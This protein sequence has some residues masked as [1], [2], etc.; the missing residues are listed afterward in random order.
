VTT[1]PPAAN[2]PAVDPGATWP[3]VSNRRP[4][5]TGTVNR[6]DPPAGISPATME[7]GRQRA[8]DP[9]YPEWLSHVSGAAGCTRPIRLSGQIH[10]GPF[11]I[12]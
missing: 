4:T 8:A 6:V 1:N 12:L 5:N 9:E 7:T 10:V 2:A 3:W 11:P